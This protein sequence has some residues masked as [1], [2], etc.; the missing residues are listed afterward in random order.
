M[1]N[2]EDNWKDILNQ[3]LFFS[4]I[5]VHFP[6]GQDLW[7]GRKQVM[8]CSFRKYSALSFWKHSWLSLEMKHQCSLRPPHKDGQRLRNHAV[9]T[10]A[11][12]CLQHCRPRGTAWSA[13]YLG[14]CWENCTKLATLISLQQIPGGPWQ[15]AASPLHEPRHE[16]CNRVR[17][18][19]HLYLIS[20]QNLQGIRWNTSAAMP[21]NTELTSS[22]M[23]LF[24]P[25]ADSILPNLSALTARV[26]RWQRLRSEEIVVRLA[27]NGRHYKLWANIVLRCKYR[28]TNVDNLTDTITKRAFHPLC[29]QSA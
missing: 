16:E 28:H 6:T 13:A 27:E 21:A 22:F 4:S 11:T 23:Y 14:K 19:H 10:W 25:R 17:F 26:A 15:A 29:L 5:N 7:S 1:R 2:T 12:S 3:K 18:F 9:T 20:V 8:Q 24:S